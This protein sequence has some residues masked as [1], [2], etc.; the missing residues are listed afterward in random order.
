MTRSAILTRLLAVGVPA[1]LVFAYWPVLAGLW[2]TWQGDPDYSA[3]QLVPPIIVY[4]LWARRRELSALPIRPC[5]S[6]LLVLL[7]SQVVRSAGIVLSFG[8]L[9]HLSLFLAVF[10]TVLFVLGWPVT[11]KLIWIILFMALMFPL[12][13][14]VHGL[15]ALP[16]QN[17]ATTSA[18]FG[19]EIL[20]YLVVREGNVLWPSERTGVAIAEACS[21]LRMLTSFVIVAATLA[22]IVRRPGWQK[23]VLVLSSMPVAILANTLRLIATVILFDSVGSEVADRFFHDFAG[24]TMMPL[25]VLI[26]VGELWLLRVIGGSTPERAGRDRGEHQGRLN[27]RAVSQIP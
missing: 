11:R 16:L 6:G 9:E 25:A 23:A 3:G 15:V 8:S 2:A 24:L 17:F 1:A 26:M 7:F 13:R 20:G 22:F 14:R 10:G 12:P 19:L 4:L 21:G 5:W 18:V 27:G